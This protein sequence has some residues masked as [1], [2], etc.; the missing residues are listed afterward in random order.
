MVQFARLLVIAA[1]L[2]GCVGAGAHQGDR[3]RVPLMTVEGRI[4]PRVDGAYQL[5]TLVTPND[6][7]ALDAASSTIEVYLQRYSNQARTTSETSLTKIGTMAGSSRRITLRNLWPDRWYRVTL[8]AFKADPN[9]PTQSVQMTN[10]ADNLTEFDTRPVNGQYDAAKNVTFS[11]TLTN[12]VF[13]GEATASSTTNVTVTPGS[14]TDPTAS[15][16]L[17]PPTP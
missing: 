6:V 3:A 1:V 10:D 5:K 2:G 4:A 17:A 7:T 16:T 11:L 14:I 13:S 9:A 12:Q 15:E 8:R